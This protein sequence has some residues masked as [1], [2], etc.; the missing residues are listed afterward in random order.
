[1]ARRK[2]LR[3]PGFDAGKSHRAL[4]DGL[5]WDVLFRDKR[6]RVGKVELPDGSDICVKTQAEG[7]Q[8]QMMG[9]ERAQMHLQTG[10]DR[11]KIQAGI[12]S[13]VGQNKRFVSIVKSEEADFGSGSWTLAEKDC[14]VHEFYGSKTGFV[15]DWRAFLEAGINRTV[16]LQ[17]PPGCGKSAFCRF[18]ADKFADRILILSAQRFDKFSAI[19]WAAIL[20]Y[21]KPD[22]VVIDDVDCLSNYGLDS[23]LQKLEDRFSFE[24]SHGPAYP[25][26]QG[27][28]T[29]FSLNL[30]LPCFLY[31]SN[32]S[33]AS[34]FS[35]SCRKYAWAA[36]PMPK[37]V[38]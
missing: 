29:S 4:F 30:A 38:P 6:S 13:V 23:F 16:L 11:S 26:G 28:Q 37:V 20:D 14:E 1:M 31:C 5:D 34:S 24:S 22:S 2:Q 9:P 21:L 17:G 18:V 8:A 25:R 7:L 35:A 27:C 12:F 19:E 15:S 32:T 3:G 10:A 33:A 36:F